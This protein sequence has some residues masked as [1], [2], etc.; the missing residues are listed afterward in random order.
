[1]RVDGSLAGERRLGD[2]GNFISAN[3]DVANGIELCF[4]VD[5]SPRAK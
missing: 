3:A 2:G 1:V 4:G 5:N